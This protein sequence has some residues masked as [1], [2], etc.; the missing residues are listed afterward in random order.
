MLCWELDGD[1]SPKDPLPHPDSVPCVLRAILYICIMHFDVYT[2]NSWS[3]EE[4]GFTYD[5]I[6]NGEVFD[7]SQT[8]YKTRLSAV[9]REGPAGP[10][11]LSMNIPTG[12][13]TD[14]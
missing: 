13:V 11:L 8:N 12:D 2:D 1:Y 4:T 14:C 7:S 6:C 9:V 5:S 10:H 3:V